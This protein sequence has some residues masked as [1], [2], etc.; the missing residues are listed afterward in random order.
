M[1]G[2]GA[3][4]LSYHWRRRLLPAPASPP[5][6]HGQP[7]QRI[8]ATPPRA[9]R[10]GGSTAVNRGRRRWEALAGTILESVA[11]G[12]A[13]WPDGGRQPSKQ[14]GAPRRTQ[15]GP[16][17]DVG[18]RSGR[19]PIG[20]RRPR[21]DA[22]AAT[23]CAGWKAH[24]LRPCCARCKTNAPLITQHGWFVLTSALSLLICDTA[25]A[26]TVYYT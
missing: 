1:G 18:L 24:T 2:A 11:T 3:A 12:A 23:P 10:V 21:G 4:H 17:G 8:G 7:Q 6:Q 26:I 14:R 22:P 5:P 16:P 19:S 15:D 25:A 13:P 9:T 20:R